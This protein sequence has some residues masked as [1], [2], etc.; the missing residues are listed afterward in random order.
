MRH[1]SSCGEVAM[2]AEVAAQAIPL[3]GVISQAVRLLAIRINA[4]MTNFHMLRE[5][6]NKN[7]SAECSEPAVAPRL[8]RR[9]FVIQSTSSSSSSGGHKRPCS[10][11]RDHGRGTGEVDC[12]E[13]ADEEDSMLRI[14]QIVRMAV[15]FIHVAVQLLHEVQLVFLTVPSA[16]PDATR[17]T[18]CESV[19]RV[20]DSVGALFKET[21]AFLACVQAELVHP[22]VNTSVISA[23][24]R[25]SVREL[26]NLSLF[27]RTLLSSTTMSVDTDAL[28]RGDV[29]AEARTNDHLSTVSAL[30]NL[31]LGHCSRDALNAT[32]SRNRYSSSCT[33]IQQVLE[34]LVCE[35]IF[36][37]TGGGVAKGQFS[38]L[39]SI[40]FLLRV[41]RCVYS[42]LFVGDVLCEHHR[43][44]CRLNNISFYNS[45]MC[46]G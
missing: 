31:Y 23:G 1:D 44:V 39:H 37:E 18:S 11:R 13:R 26:G 43:M 29:G 45:L 25:Q 41:L 24:L 6:R 35:R 15:L 46:Q 36:M 14:E 32:I 9:F 3:I 33:K 4:E 7:E 19:G 2:R 27:M 28:Q 12:S 20:A 22:C 8:K 42:E 10:A 5:A 40:M 17:S 16:R 30:V 21:D 38:P 34:P